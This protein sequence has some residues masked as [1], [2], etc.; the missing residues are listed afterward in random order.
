[1][2]NERTVIC[3]FDHPYP[4]PSQGL[5]FALFEKINDEYYPINTEEEFC[6]T[7][8]VFV[9]RGYDDLE[10]KFKDNLF[11]VV[12]RPTN[13]DTKE[14]NCRYVT[15][16]E[17]ASSLKGGF[18]CV[19]GVQAPSIPD[20][21]SP[22]IKINNQ[23]NTRLI[24]LDVGDRVYGPFNVKELNDDS[25][26]IELD[27]KHMPLKSAKNQSSLPDGYIFS[28]SKDK[29]KK[30]EKNI[31]PYGGGSVTYYCN[32]PAIFEESTSDSFEDYMSD[33]AIISKYGSLIANSP[34][35]KNISKAHILQI[36]KMVSAQK[37]YRLNKPRYERLFT[38]LNEADNW[39]RDR[40]NLITEFLD[41]EQGKEILKQYIDENKKDYL[42]EQI[43]DIEDKFKGRESEIKKEITELEKIKSNLEKQ[44]RIK[45]EESR[46]TES[47]EYQEKI[48]S[49]RKEEFDAEITNKKVELDNLHKKTEELKKTYSKYSDLEILEKRREQLRQAEDILKE[50]ISNLKN[51]LSEIQKEVKD[52]N[53]NLLSTLLQ[54]KPK[55]DMLSGV[56]PEKKKNTFNFNSPANLKIDEYN[57]KSQQEYLDL[58]T[59]QLY[60]QGRKVDFEDLVNIVVT[61]SQSQFTLFSGLPGTGKTSLAKLLMKAMGLGERGLNVPVSRGWTSSRDIV[62][63]Y[64]ALSQSFV[65]SPTNFYELLVALQDKDDGKDNSLSIILLDEMNLSQPEH[66]F[67]P[68]L[69]MADPESSRLIH[70]GDPGRPILNIP[71]HIRFLG[72]INNDESVQ[73]LTPRMLDRSAIIN[74]D[75]QVTINSVTSDDFSETDI[76]V[77]SGADYIR[78]FANSNANLP[79]D[80]A[81]LFESIIA[82]L[83]DDDPK[84]GNQVIV[85]YRKIKAITDYYNVASSLMISDQLT[86]FDYAI[87]QH[88]MPLISGYGIGFMERLKKLLS[89]LEP[90]MVRS[91][92][93]LEKIII[94]GEQNLHS[95]GAI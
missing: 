69:E 7:E 50:D 26:V 94:S 45:T 93:M 2:S 90:S 15:V 72:T 5:I 84:L 95:F 91:R 59:E 1:M 56:L 27:V 43:K 74:F 40:D 81:T 29:V 78:L 65:S 52:E 24:M 63:Y 92:K 82:T 33:D 85:S 21:N 22:S 3:T 49:Q 87:S 66:Y 16:G 58:L 55:V 28:V 18:L 68:F 83:R 88:V 11:E 17:S 80:V 6:P 12:V 37:E 60:K 32:L 75:E 13:Q 70:T 62:G 42:E 4:N 20:K 54:L 86:A 89:I 34:Q 14:G 23:I 61:L 36:R 73:N 48:L 9:T 47:D 41:K 31:I 44:I 46:N 38:L 53:N 57:A 25:T 71:E 10:D 30:Y 51:Q 35:I 8:R 76:Q 64:N 67:S 77:I 19:Q 39:G 79:D